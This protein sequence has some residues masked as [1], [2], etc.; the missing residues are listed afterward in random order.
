VAKLVE[1]L[2][3]E[4]QEHK[5]REFQVVF[6]VLPLEWVEQREDYEPSN[7]SEGES[8]AEEEERAERAEG[9]GVLQC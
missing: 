1:E 4:L 2:E 9:Q 5:M 6:G 7:P 8:E 3:A